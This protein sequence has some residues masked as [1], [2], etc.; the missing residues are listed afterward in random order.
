MTSW[1][2]WISKEFPSHW[3]LAVEHG[4]WDLLRPADIRAGDDVFFW[5]AGPRSRILGWTRA[6][7][8]A[9]PLNAG[10]RGPWLDADTADY[11]RRFRFTLVSDTPVRRPRW[12]EVATATG[13]TPAPRTGVVK[14][15][16]TG[17]QEWLRS[18]FDGV[19][20]RVD[21][22]FADNVQVQ[23]EDLLKDTRERAERTIAL[24]RGQREFR[25]ALLNAY[26]GRCAVTASAV[27]GVLEAAHI[28]PHRGLNTNVV[29]NGLLLRA[30]V[31]TLFDLHLLTVNGDLRVLLSP[32]LAGSEYAD[33]AGRSL[34]SA[35]LRTPDEPNREALRAHRAECPWL[36]G[37][38]D[39]LF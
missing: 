35:P 9:I 18:L 33:F 7:T 31:H 5:Q 25:S 38:L 4:L 34:A 11:R 8:D 36:A 19:E 23:L 39:A 32:E 24:R 26:N 3:R 15:D 22:R 13:L 20:P 12:G 2:L 17:V 29:S 30:D 27:V 16:D 6:T 14:T 37:T 10:Q 1:V 21:L 28:S